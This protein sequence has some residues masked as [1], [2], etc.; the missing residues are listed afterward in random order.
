ME[1]A[2]GGPTDLFDSDADSDRVDGTLDQNFLFV[3][4]ADDHRLEEQ[5]FTTPA[6]GRHTRFI[7]CPSA[8][9]GENQISHGGR[10]TVLPPQACCVSPPLERRNSPGRGRPAVWHAPH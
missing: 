3:V 8:L 1:K 5:L 6:G 9:R 2:H 10:L 4:T 7:V